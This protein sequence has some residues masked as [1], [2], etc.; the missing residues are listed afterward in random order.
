[1]PKINWDNMSDKKRVTFLLCWPLLLRCPWKRHLTSQLHR[2]SCLVTTSC[3][4]NVQTFDVK[5]HI[6]PASI[7]FTYGNLWN[8]ITAFLEACVQAMS[9]VWRTTFC[10]SAT[11]MYWHNL[12]VLYGWGWWCVLFYNLYCSCDAKGKHL[13]LYFSSDSMCG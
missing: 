2:Y 13:R 11:C 6:N 3:V 4:Q 9:R 7:N 5:N 12:Q 1:M 10:S 8:M